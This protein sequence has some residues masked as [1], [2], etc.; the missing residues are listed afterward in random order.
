MAYMYMHEL[1]VWKSIFFMTVEISRD[2]TVLE[3]S[4]SS[5][6]LSSSTH[7]ILPG[8]VVHGSNILCA[9]FLPWPAHETRR[10]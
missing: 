7:A 9:S 10:T 4:F 3:Q 1:D 6:G 8:G 2:G 5:Q